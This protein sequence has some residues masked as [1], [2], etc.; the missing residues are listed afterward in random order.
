[1]PWLANGAVI[2]PNAPFMAALGDQRNGYNLEGP[3]DMFRGIVREE[4]N[5]ARGSGMDSG[6]LDEMIDL[7]GVLIE[8]VNGIG[9]DRIGRAASRYISRTSRARG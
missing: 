8:A 2:P 4:V 7:L 5:A 3:E 1:M 9:D 6:R